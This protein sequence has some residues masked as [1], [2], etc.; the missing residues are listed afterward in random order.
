MSNTER[1]K[2]GAG[3]RVCQRCGTHR[4]LIRRYGIMFCRR[5]FREVAAD[6]GFRKF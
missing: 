5:C 1:K 6:I 3:S 2:F 4:A